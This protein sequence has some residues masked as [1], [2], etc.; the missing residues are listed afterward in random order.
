MHAAVELRSVWR[1]Y[2]S[3]SGE[4]AAL[5]DVSVSFPQGSFT[6][7]IGRSGCG[8]STL[9]NIAGAMDRPTRGEALLLGRPTQG[10]ADEELTLLRRR[11][12]G[13]V[14]Q[15]FNLLPTLTVNE[16]VSLPLLLDGRAA[17]GRV[18]EVLQA[19]DLWHRRRD[20]PHQLSGGQMQRV[21][22]ARALVHQP[23]VIIADEP[24]GN[25]DSATADSVLRILADLPRKNGVTVILA[26]HSSDA[27]A[28]ADPTRRFE[29]R[30]GK[31]VSS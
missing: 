8:K 1:V 9:L 29:M 14:F 26:T 27:A 19:V 24:T 21:A 20:Y 13:F 5:Q 23:A 6:A 16:N 18:R 7:L 15:F 25:L 4:I 17:D 10:L 30:D 2:E 11:Q 31:I 3:A 28:F 12:V 22:M